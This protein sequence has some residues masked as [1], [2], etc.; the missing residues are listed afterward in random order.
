MFYPYFKTKHYISIMLKLI[1]VK[2]SHA[3]QRVPLCFLFRSPNMK[4]NINNVFKPK[5]VS[6]Y[7]IVLCVL[8]IN[9]YTCPFIMVLVY[10]MY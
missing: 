8:V 3:C 1:L 6:V 10:C 9:M 7:Y 5:L 4:I 2:W